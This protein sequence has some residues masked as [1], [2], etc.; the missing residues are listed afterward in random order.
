[1]LSDSN[2]ILINFYIGIKAK[3]TET[4][5]TAQEND[6]QYHRMIAVNAQYVK[7]LSFE[8]PKAPMSLVGERPNPEINISVDVGAK[9]LGEDLFEVSLKITSN[10]E[11]KKEE[12]KDD[13]GTLFIAEVTYAGLFTI[14]NMPENQLEPALLIY[15]PTLLFPFIRRILADVTRDGGF[16]PLMLDPVD[17]AGLYSQKQQQVANS[18]QQDEQKQ[19]V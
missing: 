9:K 16:P 12:G 7:D 8:S 6:I 2:I 14:K 10:A 13:G 17:F 1:M 15:C 4:N 5:D 19:S 11:N 3:M 18:S